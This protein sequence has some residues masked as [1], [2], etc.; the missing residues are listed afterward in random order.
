MC[1]LYVVWVVVSPCTSH[2]LGFDMV[3]NDLAALSKRLVADC[4]FSAL[5]N[6]LPVQQ[7]S[8][9]CWRPEFAKSSRVVW[10]FDALDTKLKSAFFPRLLATA[11]EE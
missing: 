11:A 6:D 2:A 9:L 5:L 4:A 10:I 3:G 8:H 1:R 7:F